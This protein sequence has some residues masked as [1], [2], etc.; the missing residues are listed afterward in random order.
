MSWFSSDY[1]QRQAIVVDNRSGSA[2]IDVVIGVPSEWAKFWAA[3]DANGYGIRLTGS[4]GITP[5]TY[6]WDGF[7][8]G[9]RAGNIEIDAWAPD[10]DDG[11]VVCYLYFD[12]DSPT[13][14]ADGFTVA[15]AKTGYIFFG[16]PVRPT[17]RGTP[18]AV[19]STTPP[20]TWSHNP[21]D[22]TRLYC[23]ITD[24]LAPQEGTLNGSQLWEEVAI[25]EFEGT[26]GGSTDSGIW[27]AGS[28]RLHRYGG[29][30]YVSVQVVGGNTGTEYMD[31][32]IINTTTGRELRFSIARKVQLPVEG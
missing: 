9:N 10:T 31:T 17:F 21:A 18:V 8:Y 20:L 24:Y 25:V 28:E 12:I 11:M 29:R 3:I 26:N 13:D 6:Q 16:A 5:L 19:G 7:N 14:D 4:D 27:T 23:D 1:K 22:S 2:T 15:S 30:L 32:F